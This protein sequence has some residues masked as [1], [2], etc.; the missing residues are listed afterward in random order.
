MLSTSKNERNQDNFNSTETIPLYR[1]NGALENDNDVIE[2][3]DMLLYGEVSEWTER[4]Y[5]IRKAFPVFL[6]YLLQNAI[7]LIISYGVATALDTLCSQAYTSGKVQMVGI[8]LQRAIIINLIGLIPIA[9]IWWEAEQ[10][11]VLIGQDPKVSAQA[12]LFLRYLLIGAPA[13]VMFENLKRYLQAQGIMKAGTYVLI[14]CCPIDICLNFMLVWYKPLSLGLIGAP[15]ATSTIYWLMFLFLV[16]YTKF[17]DG[18]KAWGGWSCAAFYGW[19]QYFVYAGP[20]VLMV[21]AEWW[22]FEFGSLISGYISENSLA[23]QGILVTSINILYQL[24]FGVSIS[25]SNR[26]GNLLGAGLAERAK[27]ATKLSMQL[28]I[29]V[30][31]FNTFLLIILREYWG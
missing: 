3:D 10:I 9:C 26:I 1:K 6:A 15:I 4:L 16:I 27:M 30:A 17:I 29:I 5:I 28:A 25:A 20:G 31:L 18:Y 19:K 14:I 22:A 2:D 24:P 7:Q 11:F 21:C 13:F 23:S 12:A 8:Y